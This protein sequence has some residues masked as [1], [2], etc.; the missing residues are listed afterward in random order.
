MTYLAHMLLYMH[1]ELWVHLIRADYTIWT[2]DFQSIHWC[3]FIINK[4]ASCHGKQSRSWSAGF[5]RS[6]L[7][8]INLFSKEE[9]Q[10][11]NG[12]WLVDLLVCGLITQ[13]TA[14]VMSRWPFKPVF[15]LRAG[16][17]QK[18]PPTLPSVR[19]TLKIGPLGCTIKL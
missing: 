19:A 12:I 7:I 11:W 8:R 18:Q 14:M 16:S 1:I 5:T 9:M 2:S 13:L 15:M 10:F 3:Y 17:R 6:Q 4:D